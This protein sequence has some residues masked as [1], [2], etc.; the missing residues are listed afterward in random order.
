MK[1]LLFAIRSATQRAMLNPSTRIQQRAEYA[2]DIL[3]NGSMISQY[4]KACQSLLACTK[5]SRGICELF[6]F[7]GSS[8]IL[9]RLLQSC[10]RSTP[11][12]ELL[13]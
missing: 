4:I 10:N 6:V 9:F 5:Y 1:Q 3:H 2:L 13:R 11:H 7:R 12:Q 8:V